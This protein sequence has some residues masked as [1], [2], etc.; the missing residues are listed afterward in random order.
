MVK[1]KD[2]SRELLSSKR[3][4]V[5]SPRL[6][7]LDLLLK[8]MRPLTIDQVL[9]LAKGKLAQSTLYRVI[10]DLTEL[11]LITEF[12]TPENTMVV[13]L[14]SDDGSHHHHIFCKNCGSITDIELNDSLEL[15]LEKEVAKIEKYRSIEIDSHS[16]E[17]YGTCDDCTN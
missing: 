10:G 17:L 6:V 7:V 16:L 8:E 15:A 4:T 2:K 14:N 13:E 12:T 9:K 3:A 5:T 11:G 1:R